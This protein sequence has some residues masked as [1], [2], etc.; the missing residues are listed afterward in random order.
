MAC[1]K[2]EVKRSARKV[3]LSLPKAAVQAISQAI[4]GLAENPYPPGCKKLGGAEHTYRLR[5]GDYRIVYTVDNAVLIIEV[6]KIG[7]RKKIYR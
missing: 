6:V 7:H 3:L 2:L 4:D 1:Y 5:S